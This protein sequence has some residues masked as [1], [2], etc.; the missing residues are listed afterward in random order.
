MAEAHAA[1]FRHER[2]QI[3]FDLVR[4]V[5]LGK[6]EPLRQPHHVRVNADGLLAEGIAQ[7]NVGGFSADARKRQKVC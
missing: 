2:S 5:L 4:V 6:P 7:N 1:V 3:R